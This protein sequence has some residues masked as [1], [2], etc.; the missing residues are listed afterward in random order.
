MAACQGGGTG[1]APGT[2]PDGFTG[3]AADEVI[4][5]LGN[6]PFWNAEISGAEL[7]YATP[8]NIDGSAISIERFSGQGGLAFSGTLDGQSFDMTVTP[9]DCSDTMS[10]R[11]YPYTVTLQIGGEQRNGCAYTDRQPFTGDP[12]P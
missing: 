12:N 2:S 3:I 7:I 8:E 9:G 6:E 5:A 11:S 1:D 10:D 4:T